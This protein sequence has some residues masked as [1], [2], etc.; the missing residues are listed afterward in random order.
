MNVS[1][2]F[3]GSMGDFLPFLR[4]A[5]RLRARGI[6]TRFLGFPWAE[7]LAKSYEHEFTRVVSHEEQAKFQAALEGQSPERR[8]ELTVDFLYSAEKQ[9]EI[10]D[11]IMMGMH[12]SPGLVIAMNGIYGARI[13]EDLHQI[14]LITASFSPPF[15]EKMGWSSYREMDTYLLP[16][17]NR[18]RETCELPPVQT[19]A[20]H[21]FHARGGSW[22]IFPNWFAPDLDLPKHAETLHF[23]NKVESSADLPIDPQTQ[24]FLQEN[25]KP[26]FV[27]PGSTYLYATDRFFEETLKALRAL[28][29]PAIVAARFIEAC[30][31]IPGARVHKL[32]FAPFH[33]IFPL[34]STLVHAGGIG[35]LAEAVKAGLP[36]IGIS[37]LNDQPWIYGKMSELG[38][39]IHLKVDSLSSR[40][41]QDALLKIGKDETYTKRNQRY[42]KRFH[43]NPEA[44]YCDRIEAKLK[45]VNVKAGQLAL[46]R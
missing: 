15:F 35:T 13:A 46:G 16:Q 12:E 30:P 31:D 33:K 44:Y 19:K 14:P 3:Y 4:L 40:R 39:G 18:L 32:Q 41:L 38:L 17:I 45:E 5:G 24:A 20:H 25:P 21:W 37:M 9:K 42:S 43:R 28:D 10:Y 6:T 11:W 22:G 8:K 29:L 7:P 26:V 27:T 34:C 2:L 36:Q 23:L 1:I